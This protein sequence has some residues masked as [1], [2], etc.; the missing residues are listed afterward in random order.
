MK[1]DLQ[2]LPS[3]ARNLEARRGAPTSVSN[4]TVASTGSLSSGPWIP[5]LALLATGWLAAR[6]GGSELSVRRS[7]CHGAR[8]PVAA[9]KGALL[10]SGCAGLG[11]RTLHLFPSTRL[12]ASCY[13]SIYSN[14]RFQHVPTIFIIINVNMININIIFFSLFRSSSN[15][16]CQGSLLSQEASP[17]A[18]LALP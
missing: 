8:G 4:L 18:E 9:A 1:V 11:L 13:A 12:Q 17:L 3:G 14:H 15:V 5:L 16:V 2:T 7:P 6:A 10:A